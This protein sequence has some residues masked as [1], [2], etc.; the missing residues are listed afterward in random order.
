MSSKEKTLI[1]TTADLNFM[2]RR[3]PFDRIEFSDFMVSSH[4]LYTSEVILFLDNDSPRIRTLKNR[5]D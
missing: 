1:L 3:K 4:I 2:G 5:Y